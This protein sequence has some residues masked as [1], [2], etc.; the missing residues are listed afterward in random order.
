MFRRILRD[1]MRAVKEGRDPKPVATR[2]GE[3]IPTYLRN[4]S[5]VV[6]PRDGEQD[7]RQLWREI[8]RKVAEEAVN[9]QQSSW[10]NKVTLTPY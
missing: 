10:L 1:D 5:F 8:A 2:E 6:P 9:D 7:D 3:V 4:I